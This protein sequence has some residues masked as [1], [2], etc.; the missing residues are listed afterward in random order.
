MKVTAAQGLARILKTEGIPWVSTY[1]TCNVNNTLVEEGIPLIMM[2]EE[3]YAVALADAFS[4]ITNG[5]QVGVCTVMGSLNPAGLQMAY[6]ALAQ[7]YEDGSPVLCITD[8]LPAGASSFPLYD[9]SSGFRSVTNVSFGSDLDG[10]RDP[11][12]MA[13]D[14]MAAQFSTGGE[15]RRR[16]EDGSR[17]RRA[18]G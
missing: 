11:I 16:A 12:D 8:G 3:R 9:I 13:G 6:G 1:P 2:R 15:L 4:R 17:Q 5:K 18:D 14:E 7:A 10:R